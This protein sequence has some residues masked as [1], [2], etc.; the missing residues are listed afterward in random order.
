[1][2]FEDELIFD[3]EKRSFACLYIPVYKERERE[4]E[5]GAHMKRMVTSS[6]FPL[7]RDILFSLLL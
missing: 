4:R 5:C 1:M 6:C 2:I 3:N 7:E